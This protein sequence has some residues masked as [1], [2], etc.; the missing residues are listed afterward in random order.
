MQSGRV[1]GMDIVGIPGIGRGSRKRRRGGG[2]VKPFTIFLVDLDQ[3]LD[4]LAKAN[5]T[6]ASVIEK[7]GSSV[8]GKFDGALKDLFEAL[9]HVG[10]LE[11]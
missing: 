6:A 9:D 8:L 4:P 1:V 2:R 5:I 7:S 11:F 10:R 3:P